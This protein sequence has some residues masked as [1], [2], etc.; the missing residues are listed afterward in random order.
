MVVY[1]N[2]RKKIERFDL[3]FVVGNFFRVCVGSVPVDRGIWGIVTMRAQRVFHKQQA[4]D[5]K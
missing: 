4:L 3:F 2:H 5:E 1:Q